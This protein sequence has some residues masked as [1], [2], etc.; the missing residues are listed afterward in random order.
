M[1]VDGFSSQDSPES[2]SPL[3][4]ADSLLSEPPGKPMNTGVGSLSLLQVICL[5]QQFEFRSEA[6][7]SVP[8]H[9]RDLMPDDLRWS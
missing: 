6:G 5:T 1:W 3:L 2:R 9:I 7:V 4:Q 8:S